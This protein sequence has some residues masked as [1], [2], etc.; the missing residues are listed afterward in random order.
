MEATESKFRHTRAK[1]PDELADRPTEEHQNG[2]NRKRNCQSLDEIDA[3][4]VAVHD[5]HLKRFA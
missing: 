4:S 5:R 3:P 1:G 2:D